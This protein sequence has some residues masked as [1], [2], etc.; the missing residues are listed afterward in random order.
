MWANN[1]YTNHASY[2]FDLFSLDGLTIDT[3]Y[4]IGMDNFSPTSGVK[5]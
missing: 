4:S 2:Y 3:G 5:P 1:V